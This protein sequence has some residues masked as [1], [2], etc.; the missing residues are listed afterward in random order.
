MKTIK[1][2]SAVLLLIVAV[3][4]SNDDGLSTKTIKGPWKLDSFIT[5]EP[6]EPDFQF[7]QIKY[8]FNTDTQLV[9]I[10]DNSPNESSPIPAGTYDF[11][12]EAPASDGDTGQLQIDGINFEVSFVA[13]SMILAGS[14]DPMIFFR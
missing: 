6:S 2:L 4:C 8:N 5:S 1:I 9:V 7:G 14:G 11:L 3:G 12:Y 10:T 13:N